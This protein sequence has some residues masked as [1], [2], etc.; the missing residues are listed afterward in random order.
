MKTW[1]MYCGFTNIHYE[2]ELFGEISTGKEFQHHL[3]PMVDYVS[4]LFLSHR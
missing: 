1:P 4:I 2:E 3:K